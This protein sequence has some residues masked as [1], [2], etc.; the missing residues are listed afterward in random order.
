MTREPHDADKEEA[1][2]TPTRAILPNQKL[3]IALVGLAVGFI[4][5]IAL[6]MS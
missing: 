1:P 5:L 6:N 2:V 4:I 3:T